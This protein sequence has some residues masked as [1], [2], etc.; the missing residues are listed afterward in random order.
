MHAL[1]RVYVAIIARGELRRNKTAGPDSAE[2]AVTAWLRSNYST[3]TH[4]LLACFSNDDARIQVRN[5]WL[6]D[7]RFRLS[8][9]EP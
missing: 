3:L 2:N 5:P 1:E 7:S 6:I 4:K 8:P 9:F